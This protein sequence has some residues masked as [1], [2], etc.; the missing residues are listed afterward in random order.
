MEPPVHGRT[1]RAPTEIAAL[2]L[3]GGR[4]GRRTPGVANQRPK[5]SRA[6]A[7]AGYDRRVKLDMRTRR[8]L[9]IAVVAIALVVILWDNWE[10]SLTGSYTTLA[11]VETRFLAYV[12]IA[13]GVWTTGVLGGW[14][15]KS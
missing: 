5:T 11:G 1:G 10:H 4:V 6:G 2:W 14:R 15:P 12:L 8:L 3:I 9:G 7:T 13:V